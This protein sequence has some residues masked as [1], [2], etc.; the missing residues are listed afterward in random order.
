M[1]VHNNNTK[2]HYMLTVAQLIT[3]LQQFNSNAIVEGFAHNTNTVCKFDTPDAVQYDS[4]DRSFVD[5]DSVVLHF[6]VL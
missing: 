3:Q 1:F 6:N 2:E 5:K 4:D